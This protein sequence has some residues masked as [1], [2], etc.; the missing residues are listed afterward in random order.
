M[1]TK[2][3][4]FLEKNILDLLKVN[5]EVE[6]KD[7]IDYL[8]YVNKVRYLEKD[9]IPIVVNLNKREKLD[10]RIFEKIK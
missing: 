6:I 8:D 4:K 3:I 10:L 2:E 5:K 7:I 1:E 9:I